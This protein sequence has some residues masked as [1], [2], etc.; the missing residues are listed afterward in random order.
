VKRR[1]FI[2]LLGGAAAAWPQAAL[3]TAPK[4]DIGP[5]QNAKLSRYDPLSGAFLEAI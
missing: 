1:E 3:L 2:K 4:A 5:F